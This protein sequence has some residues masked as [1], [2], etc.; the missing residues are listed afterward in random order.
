MG[1][2]KLIMAVIKTGGT[3]RDKKFVDILSQVSP[4]K[5]GSYSTVRLPL[6]LHPSNQVKGKELRGPM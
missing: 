5:C 6:Y 4:C 2:R 1:I 3:I